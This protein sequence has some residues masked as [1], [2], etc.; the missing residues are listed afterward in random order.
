MKFVLYRAFQSIP[1]LQV[2]DSWSQDSHLVLH[3]AWEEGQGVAVRC[4]PEISLNE[5][6]N[7]IIDHTGQ[8]PLRFFHLC[9]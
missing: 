6:M 1:H 8:N 4:I 3:G 9:P 7:F 2:P 5:Y